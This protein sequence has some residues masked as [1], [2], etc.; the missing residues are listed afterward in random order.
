LTRVGH[1]RARPSRADSLES[2]SGCPSARAPTFRLGGPHPGPATA[3]ADAD[4]RPSNPA[5]SCPRPRPAGDDGAVALAGRPTEWDAAGIDS[6]DLTR[7][8]ALRELGD[9]LDALDGLPVPAFAIS[10]DG[11]IRWL[12]AAARN[13]I[14]EKEGVRF[15]T[16]LA[17]ASV[18]AAR[19]TFARQIVGNVPSSEAE[20]VV[21]TAD[22]QHVGVEISSVTV[23]GGDTVTGVFGLATVEGRPGALEPP[24]D[25]HLTPRQ[26]QVLDLLARGWSTDQMA[27]ELGVARETVR[28]HVRAILRAL[29]AHSR[30]E[31]VVAAHER[32]LV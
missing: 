30:L 3:I 23:R 22:G 8:R 14:G 28:N 10:G 18:P 2:P 16:V 24:A 5:A 17:P 25:V 19:D 27:Q 7:T 32:G 31:A 12:N 15:T 29:G 11:T 26:A 21:R 20:A 9:V 1:R 13:L 4:E 6:K